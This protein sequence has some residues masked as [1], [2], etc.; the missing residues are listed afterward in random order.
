MSSATNLRSFVLRP[1]RSEL[2]FEM[3]DLIMST[4][5]AWLVP[6]RSRS[7][8]SGL[9]SRK[10]HA[11]L[12]TGCTDSEMEFPTDEKKSLNLFA[13]SIGSDMRFPSTTI[14]SILLD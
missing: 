11:D 8:T 14:F 2:V 6:L 5:S 12:S 10:S 4:I 13:I 7:G 3:K 9:S 1:S